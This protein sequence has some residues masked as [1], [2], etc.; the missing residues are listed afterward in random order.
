M[1]LFGKS[2][3]TQNVLLGSVSLVVS[4]GIVNVIW[5]VIIG[6]V[7]RYFSPAQ[8]GLWSILISLNGIFLNG[9]DLGFSNALKNKLGELYGQKDNTDSESRTYFLSIFYWLILL[10]VILTVLFF[11]IKPFIPW[12][13]LFN[14][15]ESDIINTAV[16]LFTIGVPA[17][18]LNIAFS[19]YIAG[20]FGYQQSQWN[21]LLS[22]LSKAAILLSIWVFILLHQSF[23]SIS[24]MFFLVTLASSIASLYIFLNVRKWWL[25]T[26]NLAI[27]CEKVRELWRK[28]VQFAF[29]QVFAT[30]L[31]FAD[32]FIISKILG[33]VSVGDYFLVKRIYL[34]IATFH[35]AV[36]L[37]VWSAYTESVASRDIGWA[38]KALKKTVFYTVIIFAGGVVLMTFSGNYILELWTGKHINAVHLFIVLGIW[39]LIYGWNNCFS[40]FLNAVGHLKIQ[41]ILVGFGA[42]IFIPLSLFLG[43]RYGI[44]GI[45]IALIITHLP[46]AFSNPIQS[47]NIIREF[48]KEF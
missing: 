24:S 36:L 34:V 8:F 10:S 21:A 37:P 20:F 19:T 13:L 16:L 31:L 14:V 15:K 3:R 11:I 47:I 18:L 7:A 22:V 1:F 5:L 48:K 6:M 32:L 42:A 26:V 41:V 39:S 44:T 4:N 33:L 2:K 12:R 40:V 17:S 46:V 29:L 30:I 25:A 27:L 23:I 38:E 45:C 28:S 43:E 9:L 35:F